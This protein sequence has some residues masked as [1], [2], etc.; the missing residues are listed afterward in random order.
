MGRGPRFELA[1]DEDEEAAA[2]S[3]ALDRVLAGTGSGTTWMA[4]RARAVTDGRWW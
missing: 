2:V 1:M 4:A 3:R